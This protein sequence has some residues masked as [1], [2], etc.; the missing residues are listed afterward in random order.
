MR[1]DEAFEDVLDRELGRVRE[2]ELRPFAAQ[3]SFQAESP[4]PFLFVS[5]AATAASEILRGA[6]SAAPSS[7]RDSPTRHEP[8]SRPAPE[9]LRPTWQ[10]VGP[11]PE[12]GRLKRVLVARERRALRE[13][14]ALGA[15]LN[16][17]FTATELRRAFRLLALR[18]HP[19]CHPNQDEQAKAQLS[20]T[21]SEVAE[22]HRC[23]LAVVAP[24]GPIRH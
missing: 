10:P 4:N 11:V 16:A 14:I 22:H 7:F 5:H 9:R 17:D 21:F 8:A 3:H 15:D 19:D 23:L 24:V 1:R 6:G 20:R 13:L 18:Y 12:R 2:P